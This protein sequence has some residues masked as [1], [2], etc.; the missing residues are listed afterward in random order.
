MISV[1]PVIRRSN[2]GDSVELHIKTILTDEYQA[3]DEKLEV[4]ARL[5]DTMS[6]R[7]TFVIKK[8]LNESMGFFVPSSLSCPFVDIRLILSGNAVNSE[9]RLSIPLRSRVN[10]Q[11]FPESGKMVDGIKTIIASKATDDRGYPAK[12]DAD[13][14]DEYNNRIRHISGGDS[15]VGKFE[16]TPEYNHTYRALVNLQ[17]SKYSFNL[18]GVEPEGFV[19]NFDADSSDILI[20]NNQENL[21]GRHYLLLSVRGA[22]Y[23]TIETKLDYRPLK[24]HLPLK[25]YPK[26]IVQVTLYDSLFRPLAERLVY[27]NQSDQKMHINVETDRKIYSPK[28]KV[29]LTLN[30]IDAFGNPVRSSLSL[31]VVDA[32]KSDSTMSHSD[33]E[34]Y[35]YLTSELKGSIDYKLLNLSDTTSDGNTKRDLVMMT[36]GWRNYLWNS[37]RYTN[38]YKVSYPIEKGFCISGSVYDLGNSRSCSGYKLNYLD[39]KSGFNGIAEVDENNRFKIDIPFHYN[40][41]DYFIQNKN[42]KDRVVNLGFVLDTFPLP[43]ITYRK[44]ELP[45]ISYKAGY[46]KALDRKFTEIDSSNRLIIK[47]IKIP[48][49]KITA[50]SDRTGYSAP[51]KMI[52]LNKKDPTGKK[53]SGLFQMIYEEFGEKAFSVIGFG[54]HEKVYYPILVVNGAPLTASP[55]PPCYDFE[56]YA[57][58]EAI[59]VKEISDVKFYEAGSKYSQWLSPPPPGLKW[60]RDVMGVALY[61]P[62][63]VPKLYLPV[64]SLK[65]NSKSYRGNPRGAIMFPYQGIYMAREF[66]QPD[67]ENKNIQLPDNRTTIYWNPEIQT[68]STG[69]VKVS[70]YNSDL[71]GEALIRISGVSYQLKDAASTISHYMSH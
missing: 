33:I 27:N 31:A 52:D 9:Q 47:Y 51:D 66:Y 20:K 5:N 53:Y 16:F 44:N 45:F 70:F 67:Y 8:F 55:C 40:S 37:I 43:D 68:D 21:N 42:K 71:K 24:I 2:E 18:P 59:P 38:T 57:L 14:I 19:L 10:L 64:V 3:Q 63:A 23:A 34:S 15:G 62:P 48:E 54:T 1:I 39:F 22:V 41:H 29:I 4:L 13:I 26:G 69:T 56:A 50:K 6:V 61:I 58:A 46:L 7:K 28:E 36:Q 32:S 35:L 17:G 12:F 25:M 65:T 49:V 30:A 60:K 11:F